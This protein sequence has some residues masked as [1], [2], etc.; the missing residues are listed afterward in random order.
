MTHPLVEELR[1]IELVLPYGKITAVSSDWIETDG[2]LASVGAFCRIDGHAGLAGEPLLAEVVTVSARGLRLVPLDSVGNVVRGER[3][4]LANTDAQ[5][6]GL[7]AVSHRAINALGRAIDS[8][9]SISSGT[10]I[11]PQRLRITPLQRT[12]PSEQLHTGLRAIDGL[13][14]MARGQRVGIFAPSGAGKSSLLEQLCLQTR[15]DRVVFCQVGERGREVGRAWRVLSG[16]G[17]QRPYTLVA[18]TADESPSMRVRA[19][20]LALSIAE[21]AR[22]KGEDVLLV[23]DS[24]TRVAMALRELGIAAGEPPATRG[25][26]PNVFAHLPRQIER[27]GALANGGTITAVM[28]VLSETDDVDD[29]IV[30]MMKSVLDGHI[31]LSR[32]LAER[33]QFPAIDLTRS[34]SRLAEDVVTEDHAKMM[35][36]VFRLHATYEDARS[37]IETGLYTPGRHTEIDRAISA[38][39]GITDFLKQRRHEVVEFPVTLAALL[40]IAGAGND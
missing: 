33:H 30:E 21:E 36:S 22:S 8:K 2:P 6:P 11:A 35:Q 10:G 37:M 14:P 34:V 18:A 25:Y 39:E 40:N 29:P 9:G 4:S 15:C 23:V 12:M 1:R 24:V 26:T 31:I 5:Y 19:L 13:L 16:L 20:D 3:I 38:R 7:D 32:S 27:C 28:S 17:Q